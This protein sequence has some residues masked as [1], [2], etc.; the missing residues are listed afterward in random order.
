MEHFRESA[1]APLDSSSSAQSDKSVSCWV[2]RG[3]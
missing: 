3:I 2:K 1:Y